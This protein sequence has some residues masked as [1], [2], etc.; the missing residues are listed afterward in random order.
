MAIVADARNREQ[1]YAVGDTLPG[2]AVLEEVYPD[3][4][5]LRRAAQLETLRLPEDS[6][7]LGESAAS[8]RPARTSP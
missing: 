6:A 4:I 8:V 1:V 7:S 2:E 5:I 3:R